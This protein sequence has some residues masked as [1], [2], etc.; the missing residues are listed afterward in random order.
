RHSAPLFPALSGLAAMVWLAWA[1]G[2]LA[3]KLPRWRPAQVVAGALVFWMIVKVLFIQVVIPQHDLQRH[4]RDKAALLASLVPL[5]KILYLFKLKD[6]GI[7][8]YFGRP[9]L[10]LT[11]PGDLP[12]SPGPLFCILTEEEWHRW[13]SSRSAEVVGQMQD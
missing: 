4:T 2:L 8:F 9:V 13:P 12:S 1:R 3:W 10:R 11:G 5:D 6:E 7:M